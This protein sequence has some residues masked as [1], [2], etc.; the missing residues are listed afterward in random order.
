MADVSGIRNAVE[1]LANKINTLRSAISSLRE[2]QVVQE[3]LD[4]IADRIDQLG[5]ELDEIIAE[6]RGETGETP[7]S[8][9]PGEPPQATQLP[10]QGGQAQQQRR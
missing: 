5:T 8:E 9:T 6:A 10:A 4:E 2:G 7:G 3:T 1:E